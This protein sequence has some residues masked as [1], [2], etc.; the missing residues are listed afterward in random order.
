M[1]AL[2][3]FCA[4]VLAAS[5]AYAQAVGQVSVS[6]LDATSLPMHSRTC[7]LILLWEGRHLAREGDAKKQEALA[8][9][10]HAFALLQDG[11]PLEDKTLARSMSQEFVKAGV[12][13]KLR[14]SAVAHC[15]NWLSL[16]YVK[17]DFNKS[18]Q[19]QWGWVQQAMF[20]VKFE[21]ENGN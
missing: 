4:A 17:P 16:R 7:G 14:S 18:E 9:V 2:M 12:P 19:D 13:E 15:E 5:S 1:R 10:A 20:T 6:A 8:Q 11:R 3:L 21:S